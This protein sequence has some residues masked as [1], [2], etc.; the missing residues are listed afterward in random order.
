MI[1]AFISGAADC[2]SGY[3]CASNRCEI[4]PCPSGYSTSVS[5][6]SSAEGYELSTDGY[7]GSKACGKCTA[8]ACPEGYSAG[9]SCSE[10]YTTATSGK[11]GGAACVK[12]NKKACGKGG[13]A[14]AKEIGTTRPSCITKS[15]WKVVETGKSGED[16]CYACVCA[17]NTFGGGGCCSGGYVTYGGA[18]GPCLPRR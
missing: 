1:P 16:T 3:Q 2:G 15:E 12:C 11:S 17:G 4:K 9:L 18:E 14:W 5:S 7:S 10:G 6:C 13:Y 8:K